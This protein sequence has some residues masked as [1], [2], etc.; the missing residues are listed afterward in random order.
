[1]VKPA[2]LPPGAY[3]LEV[4]VDGQVVNSK[5]FTITAP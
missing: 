2:G 5:D 3:K 1:M 4:L